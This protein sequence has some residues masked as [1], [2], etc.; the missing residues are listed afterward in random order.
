MEHLAAQD[1]ALIEAF[2]LNVADNW[3]FHVDVR[4]SVWL[5]SLI[6][7]HVAQLLG[8]KTLGGVCQ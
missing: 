5:I 2:D 4:R 8:V 1:P 7:N 6:F 3:V